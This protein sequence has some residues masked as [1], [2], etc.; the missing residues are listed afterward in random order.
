MVQFPSFSMYEVCILFSA[1]TGYAVEHGVFQT[2]LNVCSPHGQ[3]VTRPASVSVKGVVGI[4]DSSFCF[5][6]SGNI[7]SISQTDKSY[8][9]FLDRLCT[10]HIFTHGKK[11][12]Y[13]ECIPFLTRTVIS[14]IVYFH[15][16]R[17]AYPCSVIGVRLSQI[18]LHRQVCICKLCHLPCTFFSC[19]NAN[20]FW[21]FE[22]GMSIVGKLF[23]PEFL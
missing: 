10:A 1:P 16:H 6:V 21:V 12:Q 9:A 15:T 11:L 17:W 22:C 14:A 5:D 8:A 7:L 23:E 3:I 2:T 13:L 18:Q 4:I 20:I 19:R